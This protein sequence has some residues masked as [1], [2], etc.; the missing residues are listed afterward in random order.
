MKENFKKELWLLL[1]GF[2][3]MF[4]VLSWFQESNIMPSEL[5]SLKGFLA[6]TSGFVL[7]ISCRKKL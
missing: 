7:Y 5:G 4:A 1:S 3:I 6:L 2:G